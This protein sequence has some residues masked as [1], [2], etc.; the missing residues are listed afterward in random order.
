MA[1]ALS[2]SF[3]EYFHDTFDGDTEAHVVMIT[4][5]FSLSKHTQKK[6]IFP[7]KKCKLYQNILKII[8]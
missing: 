6:Y 5:S 2:R 1:N 7:R 4:K 8:G 3:C